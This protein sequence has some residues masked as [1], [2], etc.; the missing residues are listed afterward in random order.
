MNCAA[1]CSCAGPY[2][3]R[4]LHVNKKQSDAIADAVEKGYEGVKPGW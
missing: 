1:G 2:G 3:H 4:L